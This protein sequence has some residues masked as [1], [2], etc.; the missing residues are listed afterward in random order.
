MANANTA[1]R[2]QIW[3]L[4][5]LRVLF[6][7]TPA[8]GLVDRQFSAELQRAGTQVNAYRAAKRKT[9]R[10]DGPDSNT[11]T[12]VTTTAVP[13]LLDQYFFDSFFIDDEDEALSVT[14][15]T[16]LHALPALQTIAHEGQRR[17]LDS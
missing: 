9:R 4:V 6:Q 3:A 1:T 10:K 14:E 13:V 16:R 5:G 12:D 17:R 2:S 15:L 8:L 7:E 11:A